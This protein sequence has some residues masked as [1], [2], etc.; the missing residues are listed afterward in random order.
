MLPYHRIYP[1][2]SLPSYA[3]PCPRRC[4]LSA[5]SLAGKERG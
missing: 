5:D 1:D 3:H 4:H 2:P